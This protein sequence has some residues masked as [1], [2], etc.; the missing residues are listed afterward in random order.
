MGCAASQEMEESMPQYGIERIPTRD[1]EDTRVIGATDERVLIVGRHLA[2][3]HELNDRVVLS[4][5][6][7]RISVKVTGPVDAVYVQLSAVASFSG[8][9]QVLCN[10]YVNDEHRAKFSVTRTVETQYRVSGPLGHGEHTVMVSK[11][12]EGSEGCL[13]FD[14]FSFLPDNFAGLSRPM[15]SAR[16]IEFVGDSDT[17]GWGMLGLCSASENFFLMDWRAGDSDRSWAAQVARALRADC[18]NLGISGIGFALN[19]VSLGHGGFKTIYPSKLLHGETKDSFEAGQLPEVDL[20]VV[21]LGGNDVLAGLAE[22]QAGIDAYHNVM[23]PAA[24]ASP[25]QRR[26]AASG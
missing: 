5:A 26:S 23:P 10:A 21:Y 12:S 25:R 1:T 18:H 13:A 15:Q 8:E 6:S 19:P 2:L 20:V 24:R 17:A 11:C 16:C 22:G 7:S 4:W 3:Q 14:G 9:Q